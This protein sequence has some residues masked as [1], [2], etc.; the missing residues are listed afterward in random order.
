[1][2]RQDYSKMFKRNER[3]DYTSQADENAYLLWQEVGGKRAAARLA[4][5]P[6]STFKKMISRYLER[7]TP[8]QEIVTENIKLAKQKQKAMDMNRIE[9]K[10]FREHGRRENAL[11]E[12]GKELRTLLTEHGFHIN[13]KAHKANEEAPVGMLHLSDLHFNEMV[14]LKHNKYDFKIAGQRLRYHTQKAI[15]HF[16]AEG[17]T[18]VVVA[19]TAD[20]LNSDRRLDEILEASTNRAKALFLSIDILNQ[21]ILDVNE[22]FNVTVAWVNGNEGR[23]NKDLGF[24]DHMVCEN[25]DEMIMRGLSKLL[26]GKKGIHFIDNADPFEVVVDVAGQNVLLI[27]GHTLGRDYTKEIAKLKSKFSSQGVHIDYV[28]F[29]HIHEAYIS[30]QFARSGSPVGDNAY[31]NRA[32]G[33]SGRA[34][35]NY[36]MFHKNGNRDGVKVDLQNIPEDYPSYITDEELH[37]YNA[38]SAE[39]GR[40]Q[41][42]IFQVVV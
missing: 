4:N 37:A 13:T 34:S 14:N 22:H 7:Q 42:V 30:D 21:L 27:H 9:R 19:L 16:K 29:G 28:I 2:Y 38:K 6:W 39:K 12:L 3:G 5:I 36:Y 24:V 18:N 41:T 20:L 33:L 31:S 17:V 10:A 1:M 32:L 23:V 11:T 40:K 15:K 35:Q 25:F 8:D 26:R